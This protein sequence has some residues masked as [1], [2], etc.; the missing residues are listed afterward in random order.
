M[1]L[2]YFQLIIVVAIAISVA[3]LIGKQINKEQREKCCTY[4]CYREYYRI[5]QGVKQKC[6]DR[7]LKPFV[8]GGNF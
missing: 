2:F 8:C 1:L 6:S 4:C 5:G 3:I 7:E